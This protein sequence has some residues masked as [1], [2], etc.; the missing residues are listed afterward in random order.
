MEEDGDM[1]AEIPVMLARLGL[2]FCALP[3]SFVKG[4]LVLDGGLM[5]S[6]K[7]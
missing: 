3:G 6:R 5:L 4:I 1:V 2:C 7:R